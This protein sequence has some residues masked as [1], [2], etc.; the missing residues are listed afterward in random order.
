LRPNLRLR[1]LDGETIAYSNLAD[2]TDAIVP[3]LE[4]LFRRR[5]RLS[6][7]FRYSLK[8]CG[9]SSGRARMIRS[10]GTSLRPQICIALSGQACRRLQARTYLAGSELLDP[11]Y[12]EFPDISREDFK[13]YFE[14][15]AL[16]DETGGQ[17]IGS[18]P[19]CR[20]RTESGHSGYLRARSRLSPLKWRR[21]LD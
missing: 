10:I 3:F 8:R 13:H 20:S 7:G 15:I 21:A 11:Q 12:E 4:K 9:E 5:G 2:S 14:P 1:D 17:P 16:T 6:A 19:Y 18:D